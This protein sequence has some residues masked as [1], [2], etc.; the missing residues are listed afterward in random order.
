MERKV[1]FTAFVLSSVICMTANASSIRK[2]CNNAKGTVGS[3]LEHDGV[4]EGVFVTEFQ[5]VSDGD[6]KIRVELSHRDVNVTF[7]DEVELKNYH[8][9]TC[10]GLDNSGDPGF[11]RGFVESKNISAKRITISKRDGSSFSNSTDGLSPDGK[12]VSAMVICERSISSEV[13]CPY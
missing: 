8:R 5:Y 3:F 9:S 11:E 12:S 4:H 1:L 6:I 2:Y 7:S 13:S 10:S